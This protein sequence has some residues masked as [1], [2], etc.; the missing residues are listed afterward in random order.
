MRTDLS[1]L[2]SST[3]EDIRAMSRNAGLDLPEDLMQQFIAV[4]P[5]FEAMVRRIPRNLGR[6]AEPAHSYRP[7]RIVRS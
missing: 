2:P 3:P 7:L 5:A 1:H 4:W 6:A